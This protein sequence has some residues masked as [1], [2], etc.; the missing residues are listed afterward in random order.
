[1]DEKDTAVAGETQVFESYNARRVRDNAAQMTAEQV[2]HVQLL[3]AALRSGQFT[4][5]KSNLS[6]VKFDHNPESTTYGK[7]TAKDCCLGVACKVAMGNG[8]PLF[9]TFINQASE[10]AGFIQYGSHPSMHMEQTALPGVVSDWYGFR[11]QNPYLL[12]PE[13]ETPNKLT[14]SAAG[15]NDNEEWTFDEIADGF[16]RSYV[17]PNL[18]KLEANYEAAEA[19]ESS[20]TGEGSES[21]PE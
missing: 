3:V 2:R 9:T 13:P 19:Q 12:R 20:V 4:Q 17:T 11:D 21:T 16:E 1:M 7:V 6:Y 15:A 10:V 8:V 5:V 14:I 18:Y